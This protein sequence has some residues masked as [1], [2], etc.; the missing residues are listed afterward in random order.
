MSS[1]QVKF[2]FVTVMFAAALAL[3]ACSSDPMM[4]HDGMDQGM[5]GQMEDD[6]NGMDGAMGDAMDSTM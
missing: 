3:S 6:M 2:W 4:E 1:K 5:E